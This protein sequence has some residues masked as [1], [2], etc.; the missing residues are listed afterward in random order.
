MDTRLFVSLLAT[1]DELRQLW[2][3]E[4]LA[5][6][7]RA[8]PGSSAEAGRAVME[9]LDYIEWAPPVGSAEAGPAATGGLDDSPLLSNTALSPCARPSRAATP[10]T[11]PP[12]LPTP[13]LNGL[14]PGDHDDTCPTVRTVAAGSQSGSSEPPAATRSAAGSP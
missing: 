4:R 9:G 6:G 1:E 10:P 7:E 11:P 5:A 14:G 13:C 8:P 12:P 3:A 2:K